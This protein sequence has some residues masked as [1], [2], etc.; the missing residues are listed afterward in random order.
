M[1]ALMD[2]IEDVKVKRGAEGEAWLLV[3]CLSLV[4]F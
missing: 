4:I 1:C 2:V 3:C